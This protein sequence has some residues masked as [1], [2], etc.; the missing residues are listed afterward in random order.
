[1][2]ASSGRDYRTSGKW[3]IVHDHVS[4]RV[5]LDTGM[6]DLASKL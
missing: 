6:P 3:L 2:H 5:D 4:V 1:V